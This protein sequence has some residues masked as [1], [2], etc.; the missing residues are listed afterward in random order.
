MAYSKLTAFLALVAVGTVGASSGRPQATPENDLKR[1]EAIQ[2][3]HLLLNQVVETAGFQKE[4]PLQAFLESVEKSLPK[5]ARLAL[6]IDRDAFGKQTADVEATPVS[7]PT[8]PRKMN[9][10]TVLRLA[11]A[12]CKVP[13]DYRIG[14]AEFVITTPARA[15]YTHVYD[16]RSFTEKP[17]TARVIEEIVS[18]IGSDH[19]TKDRQDREAVQL[20]NGTRVVVRTNARRH[21][22]IASVLAAFSR[23]DDL[24]VI[25]QARLY[26]VDAGYYQKVKSLKRV[27]PEDLEKDFLKGIPSE[28]DAVYKLIGKQKKIHTGDEQKIPDGGHLTLISR[29][30]A[31]GCL[32]NPDQIHRGLSR[33]QTILE[34]YG[35]VANVRVTPDRRFVRLMFVE[36]ATAVEEIRKTKAWPPFGPPFKES[37]A[38]IAFVKESS[39]SQ[40][41]ELADGGS[42]LVP[43]QYRP[44]SAR[45]GDRWWVLAITTRIII[46]EEERQ[47]RAGVV[48]DVAPTLLADVLTNARLKA[49]RALFGSPDDKR[50]VLLRGEGLEWPEQLGPEIAGHTLASPDRA[51][52][53]LLG[54]RLDRYD[55]SGKDPAHAVLTIT[56]VN[57]GGNANGT[58]IGGC[59][60]R[61]AVRSTDKGWV[62]ELAEP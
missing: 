1:V 25:V 45:T 13:V 23:M 20:L 40:T 16:I 46:D 24:A 26:E 29:H 60:I 48:A 37:D 51:G 14:T 10:G 35:F 57:A 31:I 12:Q 4:Q 30:I 62:V 34:G 38:E 3:V 21:D 44:E 15:L 42:I 2:R 58:A 61:Y 18:A 9:L 33:P 55:D 11:M 50:F 43:L 36:N 27:A 6:R 53:R 28:A 56:L 39:H 47:I 8:V 7:L 54:I 41:L 59:T 5:D 52:K 49:L 32:P 22:A 19:V 17:G